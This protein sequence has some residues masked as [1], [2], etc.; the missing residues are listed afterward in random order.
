M[1]IVYELL[2]YLAVLAVVVG[3]AALFYGIAFLVGFVL[4]VADNLTIHGI[5]LRAYDYVVN[6]KSA[7]VW[8]IDRYKVTTDKKSGI[9]ND[10][11]QYSDDSRYI[12]D[13][14]ERVITASMKTLDIVESLPPLN[15]L[16]QPAVWP[17]EWKWRLTRNAH[18]RR[19]C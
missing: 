9:V 8:L 13:L 5:P 3:I 17:A 12:V 2:F 1:F 11:N 10:P 18:K 19:L 6:G 16:P 4:Q 7:I 15:E 14:V